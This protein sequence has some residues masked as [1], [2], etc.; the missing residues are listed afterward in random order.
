[1]NCVKKAAKCYI[2]Y[3]HSLH[4]CGSAVCFLEDRWMVLQHLYSIAHGSY[5]RPSVQDPAN[6]R[7]E[8][9]Y[10]DCDLLQ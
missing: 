4:L 3:D 6:S 10:R 1:M 9:S 2:G 7:L 5:V 8:I